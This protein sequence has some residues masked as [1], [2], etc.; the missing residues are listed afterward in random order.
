M[1]SVWVIGCGFLGSALAGACRAAGARVLTIDLCAPADVCG[2]AADE[3]VLKLAREKFVPDTVFC[4]TATRGGSPDAYRRA[5]PAVVAAIRR[6][7]PSACRLVFCSSTSLYA[8]E[9]GQRVTEDCPVTATTGRAEQLVAAE[10]E[11]LA[12]GGVVARLAPLYGPGRCELLRRY[13]AGEPCLPG[14]PGRLLN[15]LHRDDAVAALLLLARRG[16][17]VYNV[18]GET[19]A[20]ETIYARLQEL[21]GLPVPE[22]ESAPSVRGVSDMRV[23]ATR[24]RALG[25]APQ[26]TLLDFVRHGKEG[27]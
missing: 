27:A 15:Y 25:W 22:Q 12:A 21:V 24:L 4:C 3:A 26:R 20:K 2:C 8:G 14:A 19:F 18:C 16:Q 17:G 6:V 11:V 7:V 10:S 9:R 5:Y 1:R 13:M 23:D